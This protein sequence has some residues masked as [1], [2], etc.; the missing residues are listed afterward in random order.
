MT[1]SIE[2][3][4]TAAL[5]A[6]MDTS[7]RRHVAIAANIAN[8]HTQGYVPLRVAFDARLEDAKATLRDHGRL[9][10]AAVDALRGELQATAG[11]NEPP[12]QV[13]LDMEMAELARNS[14]QFQTLAQALSRHLA[15]LALAA[16]DGRK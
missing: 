3:I 12:A 8:V 10:A 16:A 6:A 13:H 14:V 15:I 2:A 9:D 4:T 11:S 1:A 5:S 7:V